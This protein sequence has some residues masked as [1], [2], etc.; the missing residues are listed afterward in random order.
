MKVKLKSAGG[1]N[2]TIEFEID[3]QRWSIFKRSSI[4]TG[5]LLPRSGNKI[6]G[7]SFANRKLVIV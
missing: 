6:V 2:T 5:V 3:C 4:A 1:T 7:F